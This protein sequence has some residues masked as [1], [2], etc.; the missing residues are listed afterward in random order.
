LI[1]VL[2]YTGEVKYD[3]VLKCA[4]EQGWSLVGRKDADKDR[5]NIYWSVNYPQAIAS[6]LNRTMLQQGGHLLRARSVE[7]T[8]A[9]AVLQSLPRCQRSAL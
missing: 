8:E 9:M 7:Q 1:Q 6:W 4:T 3:S 5:C 2:F